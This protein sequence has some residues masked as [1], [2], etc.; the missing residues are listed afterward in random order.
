MI[1]IKRDANSYKKEV[2]INIG[3]KIVT[4]KCGSKII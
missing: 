4:L 3:Y 2:Q 1:S